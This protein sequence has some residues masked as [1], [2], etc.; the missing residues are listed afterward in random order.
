MAVEGSVVGE[1]E[2]VEDGGAV[3]QLLHSVLDFPQH[4]PNGAAHHR[5]L[6]QGGIQV[7]LDLDIAGLGADVSQV[8]GHGPHVFG[9]GHGVVIEDDNQVPVKPPGVVQ[10]LVSKTPGQGPVADDR[11]HVVVPSLEEV[12][13]GH[14]QG[15]GDGGAAVAAGEHVVGA[16][17]PVGEARQAPLLPDGGKPGVPPG[18]Q[19]VGVALMAHIPHN[20]VLGRVEGQAQGHGELHH[21][22]VR[23]QVPPVVGDRIDDGSPDLLA[24]GFQLLPVQGFQIL[25]RTDLLQ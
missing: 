19:L 24:Q 18:E 21:P 10:A 11:H 23:G 4:G 13:L 17:F 15:G 1:A 3:K 9:D 16:L 7:V 12:C 5:D 2:I 14:P 22:Q 8:P 6:P 20:G 25:R